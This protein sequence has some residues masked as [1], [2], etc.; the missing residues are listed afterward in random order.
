MILKTAWKNVWRNKVRSMVV[1]ISVTIGIFG[2]VFAV[3]VMNGAIDQRVDASLNNEISHIQI[4]REDFRQ[5]QGLKMTLDQPGKFRANLLDKEGV[6]GVAKR[7]ITQ[8]MANTANKSTGVQINGVDPLEEKKVFRLHEKIIPGTGG[9]FEKESRYNLA[10][11][12]ETLAKELNIIRYII[13]EEM[14]DSLHN[15]EVPDDLLA[16]LK[17]LTGTRFRSEDGFEEK[18]QEILTKQE[19][20][21]YGR[22]LSEEA[23]SFRERSKLTLTFLDV[24]NYQTGAMFRVAGIFDV[25]N[26]MFEESQVF[27]DID[28]LQRLTGLP[29]G[30][31]HQ[32]IVRLDNREETK[33]VAEQIKQMAPGL[34]VM[35]WKEIQPDLAMMTDLV[36]NFYAAFMIIILAALAFGIVNTMLMVVLERTKELG[37][38]TAIGMNKKRVFRMIMLESVFL[39]IIGGIV[40]MIVSKIVIMLTSSQGINFYSYSEGFEAMGFS[41]H[42][43][44]SISNTFFIVVTIMIIITGILSSIY[45]ALKALKLDPADALRTE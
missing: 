24:N 10:V 26:N 33:P 11:I 16:K 18:I 39:S 15:R 17:P 37:M 6:N 36:Q 14:L 28:D 7:L 9:Y 35:H 40:G 12:G 41:A 29:D 42:I 25:K 21:S 27:V 13:D 5:N 32:L 2:G 43:Y 23:W 3:A 45:P 19:V 4:N 30:A 38:L 1:I 31:A 8:G 20:S 22:I 44:P 34:E